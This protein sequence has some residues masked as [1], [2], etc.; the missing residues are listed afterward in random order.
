VTMK[1]AKH[2]APTAPAKLDAILDQLAT[3]LPNSGRLIF[4]LDA[5]AS[6]QPLWDTAIALQSDMF[7]TTAGSNLE[8]QLVYYRGPK[9]ECKASSWITDTKRL[10][11]IMSRIICEGG[12]TQIAKVLSH[13]HRENEKSKIAALVFVGDAMEEKV[14]ELCDV[15]SRL[16]APAFMF[17]EGHDG[18]AEQAFREIAR[19]TRG[20]YARF[21]ASAPDQLRDLLKAVATYASGGR[22]ALANRR[23]AGAT[24]LLE[25]LK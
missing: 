10:R 11:T 5:T 6:R 16:G 18:A 4:A 13:A 15:A 20:A 7:D 12:Y 22:Q 24:L 3:Q 25:Q 17:Q 21:D 2:S 23:D 8:I 19:I 1:L 9:G 14:D